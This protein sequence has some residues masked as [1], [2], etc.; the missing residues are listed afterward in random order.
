MKDE[1]YRVEGK[2]WKE[3]MSGIVWKEGKKELG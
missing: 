1:R 2:G 3:G